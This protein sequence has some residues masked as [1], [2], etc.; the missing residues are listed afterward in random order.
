MSLVHFK[1][2]IL[3]G[4]ERPLPLTSLWGAMTDSV[5][6]AHFTIPA[7]DYRVSVQNIGWSSGEIL[8]RATPN[9]LDTVHVWI[10]QQA[11]C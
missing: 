2:S 7:G 11:V 1:A 4:S 6:V 3:E 5:G 10:D 9:R 8:L